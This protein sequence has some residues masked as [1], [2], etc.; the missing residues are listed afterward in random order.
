[1]ITSLHS[2]T[3]FMKCFLLLVYLALL[4]PQNPVK[5]RGTCAL[6]SR[7]VWYSHGSGSF[8]FF[9]YLQWPH[10][11]K[12]TLTVLLITLQQLSIERKF[13]S[14]LLIQMDNCV[15]ENKNKYVF[16]FLALLVEMDLFT[17]VLIKFGMYIVD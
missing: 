7:D 13:P 15:R 17:E 10:D 11:C 8:Y 12:L 3:F 4:E 6:I 5:T 14:R 16:G 9:D 1:M 2:F